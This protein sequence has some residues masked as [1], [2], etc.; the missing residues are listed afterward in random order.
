MIKRILQNRL[1]YL[2]VSFVLFLVALP[3]VSLGTTNDW[4]LMSTIG[5]VALSVAA[6]IP[7][8]QRVLFPPKSK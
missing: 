8:L 2:S 7:P 1:S 6:I 3:L 4:R 5:M